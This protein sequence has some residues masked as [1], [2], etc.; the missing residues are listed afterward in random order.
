MNRV[1]VPRDKPYDEGVDNG[2][3]AN[4]P[5]LGYARDRVRRASWRL[6]AVAFGVL[7]CVAGSWLGARVAQVRA[8]S[9]LYER[10]AARHVES[11]DRVVFEADRQRANE[12]LTSGSD[13]HK[14]AVPGLEDVPADSLPAVLP[15]PQSFDVLRGAID[16][17]SD[18][19]DGYGAL[20]FLHELTSA[21]GARRIV[22]VRFLPW[23]VAED[24]E[25]R[26]TMPAGLVA[27]VFEPGGVTGE[28]SL[29]ETSHAPLLLPARSSSRVCMTQ[30]L[31]VVDDLFDP[32]ASISDAG[33]RW[34]AGQPDETNPAH[35]TVAFEVDGHP[36][37]VDGFLS[38]DGR[39]V[40]MNVRPR[41]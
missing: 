25:W 41:G 17:M 13:Y 26:P 16:E 23:V 35:F 39:F 37:T 22:A 9:Y 21:S 29:V 11:A 5:R 31:P 36:G 20:L 6:P 38:A 2:A 33:L 8:Q 34:F 15:D 19:I 12:L 3:S 1:V 10:Q 14:L 27:Y 28:P 4:L 32:Y 24:S 40:R 18:S 7:L 30:T